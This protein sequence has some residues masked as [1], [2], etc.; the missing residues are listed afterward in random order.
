MPPLSASLDFRVTRLGVIMSPQADRPHEAWGVLNPGGVRA[1]D[2]TLH[3]F[4]RLI[5]EGNYSR[6]GHARV[7]FEGERSSRL[8]GSRN[9]APARRSALCGSEARS[10][11]RARRQQGR[12]LL[13]R[14]RARSARRSIASD[15]A[16]TDGPH[17][18]CVR[19][20]GTDHAASRVT[21]EHLD[22]LRP[23]RKRARGRGEFDV[24]R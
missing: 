14:R 15:L 2:G 18:L 5:A 13:P 21:R 24:G 8:G 22:L 20:S 17:P 6:I 11:A 4:P 9:V 12:S 10:G 23:A 7:R 19:R 16:S 3:L 1:P